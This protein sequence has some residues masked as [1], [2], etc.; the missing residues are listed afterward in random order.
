MKLYR[1]VCSQ[2]VHSECYIEAKDEDEASE[3]AYE[4]AGLDWKEVAYG[5]WDIETVELQTEAKYSNKEVK[6]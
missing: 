5:D 6:S 3:I 4:S 1:V 2:L